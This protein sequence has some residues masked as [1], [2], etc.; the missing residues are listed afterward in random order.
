M[1]L[2]DVCPT[3]DLRTGPLRISLFVCPGGMGIAYIGGVVGLLIKNF[4]AMT[5][6]NWVQH[7][8]WTAREELVRLDLQNSN[9]SPQLEAMSAPSSAWVDLGT[10]EAESR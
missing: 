2:L 5:I 8:R 1:T 9:P 7:N 4:C 6:V 10:D 3:I